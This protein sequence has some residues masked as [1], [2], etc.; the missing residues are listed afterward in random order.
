[1]GHLSHSLHERDM[2]GYNQDGTSNSKSVISLT[3][4]SLTFR[5]KQR[6]FDIT[7]ISH[8]AQKYSDRILEEAAMQYHPR[9]IKYLVETH[10]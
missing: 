10:Q 5:P 8:Y 3:V 9:H 6:P 1:M 2:C 4:R 7:H